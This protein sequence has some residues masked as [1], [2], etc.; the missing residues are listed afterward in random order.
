MLSDRFLRVR[1]RVACLD[2]I[3]DDG[4]LISFYTLIIDHLRLSRFH[5]AHFEPRDAADG[6]RD[7]LAG[8]DA[9]YHHADSRFL[10]ASRSPPGD[11]FG[12]AQLR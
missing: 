8:T 12:R 3:S 9:E 6:V 7:I 5:D 4:G 10:A 11:T 2:N 1:G